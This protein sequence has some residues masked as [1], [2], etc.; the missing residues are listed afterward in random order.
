MLKNFIT[1]LLLKKKVAAIS[2]QPKAYIS[3]LFLS[4]RSNQKH[5]P[6]NIIPYTV[7]IGV[8]RPTPTSEAFSS[9]DINTDTGILMRKADEIP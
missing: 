5:T 9:L 8:A 3:L 2:R 1:L 4:L 6:K 7:V